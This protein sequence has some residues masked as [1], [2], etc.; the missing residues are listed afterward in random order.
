MR[1]KGVHMQFLMVTSRKKEWSALAQGL[2]KGAAV[3]LVWVASGAAALQA[4]QDK[5]FDLVLVDET[6]EDRPGLDLAQDLIKT[7]PMLNCALAS[8]LSAGAFHEASEGLGL[9]AQLPLDPGE[10][11]AQELIQQI[12]KIMKLAQGVR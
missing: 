8:A 5:T 6:L 7:N 1:T 11:Q 2:E 3:E 4:I 9:L 10:Q 12:T